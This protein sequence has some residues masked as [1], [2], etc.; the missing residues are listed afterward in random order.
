MVKTVFYNFIFQNNIKLTPITSKITI[1][2]PLQNITPESKAS[3]SKIFC[4]NN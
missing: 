3:S 4:E 2:K 1:M